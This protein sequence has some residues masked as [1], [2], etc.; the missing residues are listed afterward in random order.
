MN[1]MKKKAIWLASILT[2]SLFVV[3]YTNP[4]NQD[5]DV[6]IKENVEGTINNVSV[7]QFQELIS[8]KDGIILDVRTKNETDRGHL[9]DASFVD[10]YSPDFESKINLMQKN[11][12]IYIYCQSGARSYKA[13]QI[14][15][16]NGFKFIYNLSGGF[17]MW[18][19]EG[20]EVTTS[21]SSEE[22]LSPELSLEDFQKMLETDKAILVEF[23]TK[24]CAPCRQ[25]SPVISSIQK[26]FLNK[27]IIIQIDADKNRTL[28]KHFKLNGV[29]EFIVF[30]NKK[31]TWRHSGIIEDQALREELMKADKI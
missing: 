9:K 15:A 31:E 2:I 28:A 11:S 21:V 22:D 12:P 30:K 10:F 19:N 5:S 25:M 1:T 16:R 13:A 4:Q 8:K 7:K 23:Q 20:M 26:D 14:M 24:W 18:Q 17:R 29:P 6:Q 27:A 3:A